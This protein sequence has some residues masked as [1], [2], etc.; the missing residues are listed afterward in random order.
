MNQAFFLFSELFPTSV[1]KQKK[2]QYKSRAK[3]KR[4]SSRSSESLSSA[5]SDENSLPNVDQTSPVTKSPGKHS[6][7]VKPVTS[8]RTGI[9]AEDSLFKTPN[10]IRKKKGSNDSNKENSVSRT[11]KTTPVSGYISLSDSGGSDDDCGLEDCLSPV[12]PIRSWSTTSESS[13]DSSGSRTPKTPDIRQKPRTPL[14]VR[15]TQPK[16]LAT[17]EHLKYSTPQV[18]RLHTYSFLRSL[19]NSAENELRDPEAKR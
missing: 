9:G 19:S 1:T 8:H 7:T 12:G 18:K 10:P 6:Q 16:L 2:K 3:Q 11:P 15:V 4:D 5:D 13:V 14:S 17:P